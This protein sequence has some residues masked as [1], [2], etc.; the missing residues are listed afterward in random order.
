MRFLPHAAYSLFICKKPSPLRLCRGT[1]GSFLIYGILNT[2]PVFGR[3]SDRE[4]S[5]VPDGLFKKF[6]FNITND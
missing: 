2:G 6:C 4:Q 1:P 5:P 3:L